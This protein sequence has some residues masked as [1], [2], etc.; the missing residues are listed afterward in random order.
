M[1]RNVVSVKEMYI[2]IYYRY[3]MHKSQNMH[4]IMH[5]RKEI[6]TNEKMDIYIASCVCIR[7]DRM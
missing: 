4:K 6:D 5:K 3:N 7:N 2:I 1:P